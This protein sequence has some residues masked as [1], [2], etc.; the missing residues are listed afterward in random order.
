MAAVATEVLTGRRAPQ[1]GGIGARDRAER[2]SLV[3][4]AGPGL[5]LFAL[6]VIW[7]LYL[8]AF[9]FSKGADST[10]PEYGK[11]WYSMLA[12]NL[13]VLFPG[14]TLV[15]F[16]LASTRCK[17]CSAQVGEFG[18]VTP[19]HELQH[20]WTFLGILLTGVLAVLGGF[21]IAI[22][23]DAAW[24]QSALR[25]TSITPIHTFSFYGFVPLAFLSLV[26]AYVYGRSR[27]PGLW[28]ARRGISAAFAV[29]V[30][31]ALFGMVNFTFNEFGHSMWIFEELF[32]YPMHWPFV[33]FAVPQLALFAIAVTALLRVAQLM[34]LGE[35][36]GS[37]TDELVAAGRS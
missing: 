37:T 33:L 29:L 12:V 35:H 21:A 34:G 14:I 36:G 22:G 5:A 30:G 10:D 16:R 20:H 1:E 23:G 4:I 2:L 27:L 6:T 28:G 32:T 11:Y 13:L 24:H 15:N 3:R 26:T 19:G 9:G 18:G 25:D 17:V 31:G 8:L 7:S